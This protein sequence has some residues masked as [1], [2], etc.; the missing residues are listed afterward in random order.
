MMIRTISG[1]Q[2]AIA[3]LS[4][5][6]IPVGTRVVAI[7]NDVSSS[8]YYSGIIAEPPKFTNKYR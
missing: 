6:I 2:L 7:F 8:N 3:E 4:E 1:K 5:V